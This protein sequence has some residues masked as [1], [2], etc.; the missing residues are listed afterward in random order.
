ML[1]E[2]HE[3]IGRNDAA[4]DSRDFCRESIDGPAVNLGVGLWCAVEEQHLALAVLEFRHQRISVGI[5]ENSL[6]TAKRKEA[7]AR[8]VEFHMLP[9]NVKRHLAR[10]VVEAYGLDAGEILQARKHHAVAK[11][12]QGSRAILHLLAETQ[13]LRARIGVQALA[14]G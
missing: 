8:L 5:R 14:G 13:L 9:F 1:R 10:L 6:R 3:R 12:H 4:L 11:C 2:A 7:R